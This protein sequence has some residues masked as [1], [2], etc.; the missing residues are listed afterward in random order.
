M[1]FSPLPWM[2]WSLQPRNRSMNSGSGSDIPCSWSCGPV[3]RLRVS[4]IPLENFPGTDNL[5]R[6]PIKDAFCRSKS[7]NQWC[8][9][10]KGDAILRALDRNEGEV[11][12]VASHRA[13]NA[14][15][16]VCCFAILVAK[17]SR[18]RKRS[19]NA[20][21][22]RSNSAFDRPEQLVMSQLQTWLSALASNWSFWY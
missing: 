12:R 5:V 3:S 19:P 22:S 17:P 14:A 15:T 13:A 21:R 4:R 10:G 11:S 9:S 16:R 20:L 6:I 2:V 18:W 7:L 8:E 1:G